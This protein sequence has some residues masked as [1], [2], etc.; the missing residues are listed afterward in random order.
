MDVAVGSLPHAAITVGGE[1]EA[2]RAAQLHRW[3]EAFRPWTIKYVPDI[4][5]AR[6]IDSVDRIHRH[7][8]PIP[9][10]EKNATP[11][12]SMGQD[13]V[14]PPAARLLAVAARGR[15]L[16]AAFQRHAL[17]DGQGGAG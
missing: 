16:G 6:E 9:V 13:G 14:H 1:E 7:D 12:M 10:D 8:R 4:E 3:Y 11:V 5:D 17:L 15:A 2:V